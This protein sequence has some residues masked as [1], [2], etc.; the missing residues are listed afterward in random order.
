MRRGQSH[1]THVFHKLSSSH[2]S[3]R[4]TIVNE[5]LKF[6]TFAKAREQRICFLLVVASFIIITIYFTPLVFLLPSSSRHAPYFNSVPYKPTLIPASSNPFTDQS[7][8]LDT[9]LKSASHLTQNPISSKKFILLRAIGNDLPPRHARGQ[10]IRNLNFILE[11]E[12]PKPDLDVRWYVNRVIEYDT[13]LRIVK[14]LIDHNQL[15]T[16][17]F[18]NYSEYADVHFNLD[19]S[20]FEESDVLRSPLFRDSPETD[21]KRL[22]AWDTIFES[23]NQF[24]IRNNIVR[25]NMI[26]LGRAAGA[27]YILPWDGNCFLTDI[28]WKNISSSINTFIESRASNISTRYFYV[29]MTRITDNNLLKNTTFTPLDMDEEPQVVFHRD[30]VT[31][32]DESKPYGY[33]PKVDLL[34]RLRIPAFQFRDKDGNVMRDTQPHKLAKD[35][36]G[37]DSVLPVGWTARLY[38]GN[39][40]LEQD[41]AAVLRG[42]SRT[43]GVE[44]LTAR[45]SFR[46][47]QMKAQ[48]SH[49]TSLFMYNRN[50]ISKRLQ[51][52]AK[53][54]ADPLTALRVSKLVHHSYAVVSVD[55]ESPLEEHPK[56]CTKTARDLVT[57]SLAALFS[58]D[59]RFVKW[60]AHRARQLM[61]AGETRIQPSHIRS[62][63]ELLDICL[64]LDAA[65]MLN[66]A[67]GISSLEF[68]AIQAWAYELSQSLDENGVKWKQIYFSQDRN[69]VLFEA[70]AGCLHAFTGNFHLAIRRLGL[71]NS[72]LQVMARSASKSSFVEQEGLFG[73]E[74]WVILSQ[75]ADRI[76][77]NTWTF[78][79]RNYPEPPLQAIT[80]ATLRLKAQPEHSGM[81]Q[82]KCL[83]RRLVSEKMI[84]ATSSRCLDDTIEDNDLPD[85]SILPPYSSLALI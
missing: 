2:S 4:P 7:T 40:A 77:L 33:R 1:Q 65:K 36:P 14:L 57:V 54:D 25:N 51:D 83:L 79:T 15:F 43:N 34:W 5:F 19:I 73:L 42:R 67:H 85:Q 75:M 18:L 76:G 82:L 74:A 22:R 3:R 11:N 62:A 47:A 60:T 84:I 20:P 66:I 16:I 78:T 31:R 72:R 55:N 23:K 38:S 59:E 45:A 44:L 58:G 39:R 81:K 41:N 63:R 64:M 8:E 32:F 37:Y 17:D 70:G 49:N 48:Y 27:T 61:V 28:A 56:L 80:K 52:V 6:L 68:D 69:S 24:I 21:F 26:E 46:V 71:A 12:H 9:L 35:I 30:A 50:V 10:T 13:Q 29:P 53:G